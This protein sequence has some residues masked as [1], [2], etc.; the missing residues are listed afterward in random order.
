MAINE[1]RQRARRSALERLAR[2]RARAT[3]RSD[4]WTL[5]ARAIELEALASSG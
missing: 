2:L 1:I 3:R 4:L 5:D